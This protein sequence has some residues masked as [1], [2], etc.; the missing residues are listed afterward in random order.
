MAPVPDY[1]LHQLSYLVA[2]PGA[3]AHDRSRGAVLRYPG[4][5]SQPRPATL[6]GS[7]GSHSW[8][9]DRS[10]RCRSPAPGPAW[11]PTRDACCNSLMSCPDHP[12]ARMAL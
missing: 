3:R 4:P 8:I 5:L 1:S 10:R 11:P 12:M 7:S 9:A 2:V 6:R